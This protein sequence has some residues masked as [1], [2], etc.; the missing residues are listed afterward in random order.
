MVHIETNQN[1][2]QEE[3]LFQ[4]HLQSAY[5]FSKIEIYKMARRYYEKALE[6]KPND[7]DTLKLLHEIESLQKIELRKISLIAIA[8]AII[9]AVIVI[10]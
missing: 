7:S 3:K 5:D 9:T 4:E 8:I 6:I 2:S 10:L 1:L